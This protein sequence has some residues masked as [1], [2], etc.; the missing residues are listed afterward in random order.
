MKLHVLLLCWGAG[1]ILWHEHTGQTQYCSYAER[2][3]S[4]VSTEV[5][6]R[7]WLR[8]GCQALIAI[9]TAKLSTKPDRDS[10]FWN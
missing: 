8:Q 5:T 7:M 3:V 10:A 6:G 4:K 1:S 9:E 2:I